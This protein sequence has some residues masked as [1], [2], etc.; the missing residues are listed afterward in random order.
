MKKISLLFLLLLSLTTSLLSLAFAGISGDDLGD[1]E[2]LMPDQAFVLS[3]SV[4]DGNTLRVRW[5]IVK[6]Y[7]MYRDKFKF[8]TDTANIKL[9]DASY[10]PGKIKEDEF[11]GQVETYR[12][13]AVIDIP[14]ERTGD[15]E[16]L[17]LTT[18]SQGCADIGICYPPQT[19]TISFDLPPPETLQT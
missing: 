17:T 6:G 9:G 8:T 5:D 19:Q 3:S 1:E 10:P 4:I 2:P 13:K 14:I 15:V 16:K 18:V 12:K 7:Y 11:F